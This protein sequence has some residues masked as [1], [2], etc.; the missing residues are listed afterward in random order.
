LGYLLGMETYRTA[1]AALDDV[2]VDAGD[3]WLL[4]AT[5]ALATLGI[6]AAGT[7]YGAVASGDRSRDSLLA[8][9]LL[10]VLLPVVLAGTRLFEAATQGDATGGDVAWLGLLAVF[11][12]LYGGVGV[13]AFGPLLEEA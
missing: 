1:M 8:I 5:S 9:L 4:L 7:L 11:A 13:L 2:G 12:A 6:A 10:P 3:A